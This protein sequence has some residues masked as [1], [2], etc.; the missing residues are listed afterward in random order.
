VGA[1]HDER[2]HKNDQELRKATL[3]HGGCLITLRGAC[4]ERP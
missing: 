2:D 3:E 4:L 1:Q